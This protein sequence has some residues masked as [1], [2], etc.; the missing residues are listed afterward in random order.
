MSLLCVRK[1]PADRTVEMFSDGI[2]CRDGFIISNNSIK[3]LK[4][5]DD[6]MFGMVGETQFKNFVFSYIKNNFEKTFIDYYAAT[7]DKYEL[8]AKINEF[9]GKIL[10]KF[11]E[12]AYCTDKDFIPNSHML[13]VIEGIIYEFDIYVSGSNCSVI[14]E[15]IYAIGYGNEVAN[16]LLKE[17]YSPQ[18]VLDVVS[19]NYVYVNNNLNLE[20]I[21]Y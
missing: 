9:M 20:R 5:D 15:D 6:K 7:L 21:Y 1:N 3:I 14:N 4:L 17:N 12:N 11:H 8:G 19:K 18:K 10:S 2:C 13:I 16:V